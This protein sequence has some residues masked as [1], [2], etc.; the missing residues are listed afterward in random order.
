[1]SNHL[2]HTPS[3]NRYTIAFLTQE[4]THD[5]ESSIFQGVNRAAEE[6]DV[7]LICFTPLNDSEVPDH[8]DSN[9][10]NQLREHLHP[11]DLNG[12]IFISWSKFKGED[13]ERCLRDALH[14]IR[15]LSIGNNHSDMPSVQ[16]NGGYYIRQLTRHLA[17]EH[18]CRNIAFISSYTDDDRLPSYRDTMQDLDCYDERLIVQTAD[19][20]GY[21]NHDERMTRALDILFIERSM[22]IDAI[23]VMSAYDGKYMLNELTNRGL[24]VPEDIALVCYE[25]IPMI[26]FSKPPLTTIYYPYEELGYQACT[27]LIKLLDGQDIL[28]A[29]EVEAKVILRDSCGCA[30]NKIMPVHAENSS[31]NPRKASIE[32]RTT[33]IIIAQEMRNS[34]PNLESVDFE[35]LAGS[36]LTSVKQTNSDFL[37][38]LEM[39][40]RKL[41]ILENDILQAMVDR[42]R[43]LILP[44]VNQ[45][46]EIYD[47]A[48]MLWLMTRYILKD[49]NNSATITHYINNVE[50]NHI[51]RYVS[52]HILSVRNISELPEVLNNNLGWIQIPTQ[53]VVLHT[54]KDESSSSIKLILA[55]DNYH[56]LTDYYSSDSTTTEVFHRYKEN[57]QQRFSLVVIPIIVEGK[58]LGIIWS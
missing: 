13:N 3:S 19:L 38:T 56:N 6:Y 34:F 57:K 41:H 24:K 22:P 50:R 29:Q 9:R 55:Y 5:S 35:K 58:S 4:S 42:F 40:V 21:D 17:E 18:G 14:P 12:L 28:H 25:D 37:T 27:N 10:Y 49:Y 2:D 15:L 16:M 1:M 20:I 46:T 11:F 53:Y 31:T 8:S 52:Q 47:R 39:E 44:L 43:Q 51:L 48:E 54:N 7:N 26:E 33:S 36:F 30:L 23:M 32:T 45:Q